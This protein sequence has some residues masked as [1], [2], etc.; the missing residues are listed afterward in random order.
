V[1]SRYCDAPSVLLLSRKK[2][3]WE[4]MK[5]CSTAYNYSNDGKIERAINRLNICH[6]DVYERMHFDKGI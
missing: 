6:R 5:I 4:N 3:H 1:S 2:K